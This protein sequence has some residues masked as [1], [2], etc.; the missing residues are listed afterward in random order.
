MTDE[1][2]GLTLMVV[3]DNNFQRAVAAKVLEDLGCDH[4]L[5]ASDG[6]DALR[7]I[8]GHPDRIHIVLS[9]LD[10]PGMDGV[11]FLRHL[12]ERNLADAV[13]IASALDSALIHTVED[14]AHE[15][16][17]QVLTNVEK[18]VT[19]D[20]MRGVIEQYRKERRSRN[21]AAEPEEFTV[22]DIR[23]GLDND[24]FTVWYQPKVQI[25][26]GAWISSEALSRWNHPEKGIVMP[27]RYVP[28]LEEHGLIDL[29]TWKQVHQIIEDLRK[30]QMEGRNLSIAVNLSPVLLEDVDMPQKLEAIMAHHGVSTCRMTLELTETAVM[31]NVARS[32]E[33]LARLRMKGFPLSIDDFGTGFS[34][35]QQLNRIPFTELKIDRTFIRDLETKASARTIVESNIELAQRMKLKA[36][37][38]GVEQ[39]D[40]WNTLAGM[41]CDLVQGYFVARPMPWNHLDSWEQ[42]WQ[43]RF[44]AGLSDQ[45]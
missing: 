26:D 38:E 40:E 5:A 4:V 22:E 16:G 9:D 33:T 20:K 31:K 23:H 15:H 32:L 29:L 18:P 21:P 1:G 27:A 25:K 30:W 39:I 17:V 12:A 28:L 10:M 36:V 34:N 2:K 3:E 7:Q 44:Q 6:D 19:R 35:F 11:E 43:Q 41:G 13:V 8:V 14:M 42:G 24:E 45:N 37:A